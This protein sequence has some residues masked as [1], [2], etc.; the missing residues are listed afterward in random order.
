M[1][2][3]PGTADPATARVA[4]PVRLRAGVLRRPHGLLAVEAGRI[5]LTEYLKGQTLGL[6]AKPRTRRVFDLPLASLVHVGT[7]FWRAGTTVLRFDDGSRHVVS[8]RSRIDPS[9]DLSG[10]KAGPLATDESYDVL[11]AVELAADSLGWLTAGR[12]ARR[13]RRAW[14]EV[15]RGEHVTA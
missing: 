6:H 10:R 14:K 11:G 8:F 12:R 3:G 1:R 5:T 13:T 9:P 15:L 4:Q 7:P 2:E